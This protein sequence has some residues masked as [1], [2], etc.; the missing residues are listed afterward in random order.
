MFKKFCQCL[1]VASLILVGNYGD[2]LGGGGDVRMHTPFALSQICMAHIADMLLVTCFLFGIILL[3]ARSRFYPQMQLLF[4]AL[5]PPYLIERARSF[6][7]FNLR[8]AV[9][10]VIFALWISLLLL[11]LMRFPSLYRW[12][13]RVGGML[14]AS[15][16]IFAVSSIAQ[17]VWVARWTPAP[18]Q[19]VASWHLPDEMQ[20]P[21]THPLL[22]WIVFDELSY[23]QVFEHR[24]HDLNLPNF[25]AL[26]SQS[27][28][29]TDTQPAGYR[30]VKVIPSLLTGRTIDEIRYDFNNRL[31]VHHLSEPGWQ[32]IDGQQ[33]V[34]ADAN[35]AGWRTAAVGW[36]NPYCSL[37]G[38]AL[39]DC[40]WTNHDMFDGPMAP[41]ASLRQNIYMPLQ[42]VVREM[43]SPARADLD[44]CTVDV[45][46]RYNTE[47]DL[48]EHALQL[49]LT[50]QADFVFLHLAI[51]HS[52]N[53]WNRN[54][55][56]YTRDCGHSYLDNLALT[57]KVLG[58]ILSILQASPRW[59]RTTLIVEGDH[60]WRTNSWN[61]RA[62]WTEGDEVASRG[63]F[64]PRPA[65][66]IHLSSQHEPQT[67]SAAW[68]IIQVHGVIDK[69]LRGE[70]L[71]F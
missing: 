13:L 53:I 5:I 32:R 27:T 19:I 17:L 69:I 26:R 48:Q 35:S 7:S 63:V 68:P 25:D 36:Y 8:G 18:N 10:M 51:P 62:A 22:V 14:T 41:G 6:F 9:A 28:V 70:P 24:A 1:G 59:N 31:W 57:D 21:R 55:D 12:L 39:Q 15:L 29:F 33:T 71:T 37:Y 38:D 47:T 3:V 64:D 49:L 54:Q 34:F 44:L 65:L 56:D 2:L 42:Q 58:R 66:I 45:H 52:P 43:K 4:I 46:N 50:D 40:Y 60:G 30:T 11:L 67:V 23:D 16:V 61:R 20:I